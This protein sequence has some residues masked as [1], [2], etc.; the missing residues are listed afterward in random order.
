MSFTY[1]LTAESATVVARLLT[2]ETDGKIYKPR[3]MY[4]EYENN[5]GAP[6]TPPVLG[7]PA[8][9]IAYYEALSGD[10]D[11]LR[12]PVTA[13]ILDTSDEETYPDGNVA[14]YFAQT[15]GSTGELGSDFSHTVSSRVYGGAIVS[16][17]DLDDKTQDIVVAR[18]YYDTAN[19]VLKI[20][21]SQI[22]LTVSLPLE[23]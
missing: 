17:P 18:F 19:Q 15:A 9:G 6:V 13:A 12:V 20:S 8:T 7:D 2:G 23:I 11:Y 22:N 10:R 5:G 14:K 16:A 1:G 3:V 21:G 4:I